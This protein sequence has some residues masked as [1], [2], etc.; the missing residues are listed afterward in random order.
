M[1]GNRAS[2][3]PAMSDTNRPVQ[4]PKLAKSLKFRIQI[5]E[6]LYYQSCE[7]KGTDQLCSSCF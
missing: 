3:L 7:N 5:E 4:S 1:S 6:G 2:G